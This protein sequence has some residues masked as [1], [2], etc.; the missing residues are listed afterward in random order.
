MLQYVVVKLGMHALFF[1]WATRRKH[2]FPRA[3][4]T[5][6]NLEAAWD[7]VKVGLLHHP[8]GGRAMSYF[9]T[10]ECFV[11]MQVRV[12]ACVMSWGKNNVIYLREFL[13]PSYIS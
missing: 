13:Q 10:F 2:A 6:G 9:Y 1:R 4:P 11:P 7:M 5:D 12:R 8:S 3:S